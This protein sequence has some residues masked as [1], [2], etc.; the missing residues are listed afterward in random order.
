MVKLVIF[1]ISKKLYSLYIVYTYFGPSGLI[2]QWKE[3]VLV[4]SPWIFAVSSVISLV[5]DFGRYFVLPA[6]R[7]GCHSIFHIFII[8]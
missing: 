8:L 3:L 7:I 4:V 2:M 1:T 6:Y 5:R